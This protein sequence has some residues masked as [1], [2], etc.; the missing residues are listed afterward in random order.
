MNN[1]EKKKQREI[2]IDSMDYLK[3]YHIIYLY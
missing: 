3:T 1:P 2:L